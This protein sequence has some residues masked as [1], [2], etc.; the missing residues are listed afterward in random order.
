VRK[1]TQFQNWPAMLE[2]DYGPYRAVV[3]LQVDGDTYY[4]LLDVGA[5]DY[6]FREIRLLG[7][8]PVTRQP[9]GMDTPETNRKASK[10]AGLAAAE[11]AR[12]YLV[13]NGTPIVLATWKDPDSFGRYLGTMRLADGRDVGHELV[14]AGHAV[15]RDYD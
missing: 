5:N 11:F 9:R 10:A 3:C 14:E 6:P 8:D 13:P 15:W 2:I 7:V 1:P 12:T 4:C